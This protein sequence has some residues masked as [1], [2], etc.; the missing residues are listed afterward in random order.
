MIVLITGATGLVGC[1]ISALFKEEG[2]TVHYLSTSKN[3]IVTTPT[4]KGFYWNPTTK[5]IDANAFKGVTTIVHLAG[6]SVAKRWTAS[7]KKAIL[8]SRIDSAALIYDTLKS[9]NHEVTHFITAS[10]IS[11]YPNSKTK[12]YTEENKEVDDTFLARVVVAWEAAADQFVDLGLEV[13][14][15]RTGIV[16][17][18]NEGALPKI[19]APIKVG[20]GATIGSGKQWQS[21]IHIDDLASV[22]HC[23]IHKQ[24]EGVYNAVAPNPVTN[25]KMTKLIA[26]ILD[27]T[28]W[29]P[30]VPGFF[31][32]L[33]L[34]DMA[35]IV[36][37][38]QLVS[39]QK[40]EKKGF[41]FE[42]YNLEN[43]LQD[44][45]K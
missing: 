22:Y 20:F 7:Y 14:K 19:L 23:I 4:Y 37:E 24:W 12:L 10:G 43:A 35:V 40:L 29:L 44:L 30:D 17:D 9:L 3:K 6:A 45:L 41:A 2:V 21:W 33:I 26:S 32:R 5:E 1:K 8:S 27:K 36:L 18:K 25:K 16:L 13:T 39:A 28:L 15:V 42:F 31:L 34:G 38:G 11:V